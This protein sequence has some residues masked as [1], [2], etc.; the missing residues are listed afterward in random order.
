[1]GYY[2]TL[3]L[4]L[5]VSDMKKLPDFF[6]LHHTYLIHWY[7]LVQKNYEMASAG[8]VRNIWKCMDLWSYW[9][10]LHLNL[11]HLLFSNSFILSFIQEIFAYSICGCSWTFSV[12]FLFSK[13]PVLVSC[14]WFFLQTCFKLGIYTEKEPAEKM[15]SSGRL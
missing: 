14:S 4:D 15:P 12:T 5:L 2:F 7:E 10:D 11:I 8:M 1:M 6:F 9:Y 13:R 3:Y